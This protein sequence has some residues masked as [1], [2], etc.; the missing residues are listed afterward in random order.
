MIAHEISS[1]TFKTRPIDQL[2]TVTSLDDA[3][4]RYNLSRNDRIG[5]REQVQIYQELESNFRQELKSL[6][7]TR[8]IDEANEMLRRLEGLREEF[9]D[10]QISGESRFRQ[11]Q[12]QTFEQ[13]STKVWS[14]SRNERIRHNEETKRHCAALTEHIHH[15]HEI[16]RENLELEIKRMPIPNTKH[17]KRCLE[18]QRTEAR[19]VDDLHTKFPATNKE[20]LQLFL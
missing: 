7:D 17:S 18:L 19:Y 3:L 8:R 16:Q 4:A 13:A 15:L 5:R 12:I 6:S 2:A 9:E 11:D 1:D 10:L 20:Q 14:Q